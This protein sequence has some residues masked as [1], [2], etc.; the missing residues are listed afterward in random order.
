MK[1]PSIIF[2]FT[3]IKLLNFDLF[4]VYIYDIKTKGGKMEEIKLKNNE[5]GLKVYINGLPNIT[6]MAVEKLNLLISGIEIQMSSYFSKN[7][8]DKRYPKIIFGKK[9]ENF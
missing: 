3:R 5:T 1:V 6:L 2:V 4:F 9:L 8:K 7:Q